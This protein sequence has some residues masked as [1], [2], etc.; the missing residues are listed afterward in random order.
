MTHVHT[1]RESSFAS[2]RRMTRTRPRG[3][4]TERPESARLL[5]ARLFH[6]SKRRPFAFFLSRTQD[7]T[8]TKTTRSRLP[9]VRSPSSPSFRYPRGYPPPPKRTRGGT[10]TRRA[11]RRSPRRARRTRRRRFGLRSAR[12]SYSEREGFFLL[13]SP[14]RTRR[15]TRASSTKAAR[16]VRSRETRTRTGAPALTGRLSRPRLRLLG[17][18]A[19]ASFRRRETR[20]PRPPRTD[21][22]ER[23]TYLCRSFRSSPRRSPPPPPRRLSASRT[24]RRIG[25]N[26][27]RDRSSRP[28][29]A[30]TRSF[31]KSSGPS[32]R[33]SP[34]TRRRSRRAPPRSVEANAWRAC[35]REARRRARTEAPLPRRGPRRARARRRGAP[36][37]QPRGTRE[38]LRGSPR[39]RPAKWPRARRRPRPPRGWIPPGASATRTRP[40]RRATPGDG[41]RAGPRTRRGL[42]RRNRRRPSRPRG[43]GPPPPRP[44]PRP[45]RPRRRA[46]RGPRGGW[47]RPIKRARAHP[48]PR[49]DAPGA[50]RAPRRTS[51]QPRRSAR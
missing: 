1:S 24:P 13:F 47:R 7:E 33:A 46:A 23:R 14:K 28:P 15:A 32:R 39:A 49:K 4:A 12:T 42:G 9:H 25:V 43:R 3:G 40:A 10:A 38:P 34:R 2:R 21:W 45:T 16:V 48:R 11:P 36:R 29:R 17:R 37:R 22:A 50:Q 35:G 18:R 44:R 26:R 41:S 31:S 51:A 20:A 30:P 6:R 5:F 19:D 27:F 8:R